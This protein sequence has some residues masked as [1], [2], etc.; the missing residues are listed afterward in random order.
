[1]SNQSGITASED[2]L[3]K[4]NDYV[5]AGHRTLLIQ[6]DKE[7]CEHDETIE[8]SSDHEADFDEVSRRLT[9][10]DARYIVHKL[11]GDDYAFISFVPDSAPVRSKMLY[12]SSASTVQRQLGGAERFSH[13]LFWTDLDEVSPRGWRAHKAHIAAAAPETEEERSLKQTLEREADQMFSTASRKSHVRPSDSSSGF[14]LPMDSEGVD[15][16]VQELNAASGN[17]AFVLVIDENEQV[18]VGQPAKEISRGSLNA[19]VDR[20]DPQYTLFKLH[21]YNGSPIVLIYTCPSKS[22]IKKRVLYAGDRSALVSELQKRG[23]SIA[24]VIESTDAEE[25]TEEFIRGELAYEQA[26]SSTP[27]TGT[28]T[29]KFNRPKRPGRR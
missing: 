7:S 13:I 9:P 25:V 28:S 12:A 6:I 10:K 4:F 14:S 26:Q 17:S 20:N 1:M 3:A 24:K 19:V 27:S 21:D 23:L 16:A 29:P 5:A 15:Q 2:L 22:S 18:V 11:E 8:G